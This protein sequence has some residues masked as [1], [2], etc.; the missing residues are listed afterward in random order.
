MTRIKN[1]S[2]YTL[3]SFI[4][5]R[6]RSIIQKDFRCYPSCKPKVKTTIKCFIQK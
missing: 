3:Q 4:L 5:L 6:N 1:G 2:G